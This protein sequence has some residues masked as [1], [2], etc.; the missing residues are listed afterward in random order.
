MIGII[1]LT[2][3]GTRK[4]LPCQ[5]MTEKDDSWLQEDDSWRKRTLLR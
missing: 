1:R 5:L 2:A 3:Q 4:L